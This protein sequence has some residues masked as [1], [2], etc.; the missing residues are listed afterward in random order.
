MNRVIIDVDLSSRT[1]VSVPL[2]ENYRLMGGRALTSTLVAAEVDPLCHAL[3]PQN[4]LVFAPGLLSGT[5]LSSANRLSAGAKSPLTGTIKE[6]NSGGVAAYRLGRLGIAALRIRGAVGADSAAGKGSATASLLGLKIAKKGVSF[7]DLSE[8]RGMQLYALSEALLARYGKTAALIMIGPAGEQLLST[9]CMSVND[10]EGEP[11]RNLARGGLGAVMGSKGLKAI[12]IDDGGSKL[13]AADEA[14]LKETSRDYVTMLKEHPVTGGRFAM[15]GTA[16]TMAAVNALGGLP[17]R[18]FSSGTFEGVDTIGGEALYQTMV[19]RGG[20]HAHACMPGCVIRCSNKY[21][22]E[23]GSP[24]V[25]SVDYETLCLMGSNLGLTNLDEVVRLNRLCNEIGIDTIETGATLGVLAEAGVA[26]FGNYQRFREL[27]LEI[28]AATPLGKLI[29]SG[30]VVCGRVFGVQRVPAVK[31]QAMAAYDPR[32]I[33]GMG[34]TYAQTPMGAD[35]TAGNAIVLD[36]DHSDPHAQL[37]LVR[38]LN[39]RTM[40]LDSLGLC[41]FTARVTLA[42]PQIVERM[43]AAVTGAP[44][45]FDQLYAEAATAL[46]TERDFN[47]RA[48]FTAEHDRL[49]R[50]MQ[51]EA[52]PPFGRVA[53]VP[54][55]TIDQFYNW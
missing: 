23:D 38:Q 50:F 19:K 48:G 44:L 15:Y 11:C 32:V 12:I 7:E 14:A 40:V 52:L 6:A 27:L 55:A 35:H 36:V 37:D 16:A 31:G 43:V 42:Q 10:P 46:L 20:Q 3:S 41:I 21:V 28:P 18:N 53:D 45:T 5:T 49:P 22:E 1:T 51:T 29:G 39:I 47:R 13:S 33:K 25:G 2:P 8:F 17:T 24:L 26:E 30:A 34:I 54:E 9:A 4:T